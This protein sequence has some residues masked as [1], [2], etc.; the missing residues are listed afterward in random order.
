[1]LPRK[2]GRVSSTLSH[3]VAVAEFLF[4]Y[5][6]RVFASI[7]SHVCVGSTTA[8]YIMCAVFP[9]EPQYCSRIA[10]Y[11]VFFISFLPRTIALTVSLDAFFGCFNVGLRLFA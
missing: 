2:T 1:M 7:V 11:C 9:I 8:K 6:V 4:V 5:S 3:F 10:V